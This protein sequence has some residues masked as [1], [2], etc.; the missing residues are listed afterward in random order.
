MRRQ[1]TTMAM[2]M[3]GMLSVLAMVVVPPPADDDNKM[4]DTISISSQPIIEDE[5]I[6]DSLLNPRWKIQRTQPITEED[7]TSTALDLKMP[8]NLKHEVEYNDTLDRYIFGQCAD[9]DDHR[10]LYEVD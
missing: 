8:E 9:N 1:I 10:R 3:A 6:P 2:I 4:K 7:L 5:D